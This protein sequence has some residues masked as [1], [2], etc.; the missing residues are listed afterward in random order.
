L[1]SKGGPVVQ[2]LP[3]E[4]IYDSIEKQEAIQESAIFTRLLEIRR[5]ISPFELDPGMAEFLKCIGV[6]DE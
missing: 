2:A 1:G 5:I 3:N 6:A 4:S